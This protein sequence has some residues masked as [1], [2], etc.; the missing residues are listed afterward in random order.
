VHNDPSDVARLVSE[1]K[2]ALPDDLKEWPGGWPGKIE[3]ALMDAVL[4]IRASYGQGHNGVR[5]AIAGWRTKRRGESLDDLEAIAHIDGESLAEIIG[6]HQRLSGG[7]LKAAAI[8]EAAQNLCSAGVRHAIDLDVPT[9]DHKAAYVSVH[10]LGPVTWSYFLM[11]LGRR[12]VKPDTWIIRF[13]EQA[14]DRT[15]AP[16]EA[17][18]LLRD[19]ARQMDIPASTLDHRVWSHMRAQAKWRRR[20]TG[21]QT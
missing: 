6:N 2:R 21:S 11:L 7:K 18:D 15:V 8:I 19:T 3:A 5:G 20:R 13:V 1:M 4:S 12:D 9:V 16:T 10:G 17:Q 14:L